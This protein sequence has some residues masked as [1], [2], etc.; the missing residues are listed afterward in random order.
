MRLIL[1]FLVV[2][3]LSA[4]DLQNQKNIA[5]GTLERDRIAHAATSNEV[6]I[7]LPVPKGS[8]V[9]KGDIL[10]Q[11]DPTQ[12][13]A[14]VARAIAKVAEAKA[15]FEKLQH[16][17]RKEEIA[18]ARANVA[19][20]QAT[21]VESEANYKRTQNLAKSDLSSQALLDRTLADRDFHLASLLSV[22]EQLDALIKGTRQEDLD[23]AKA[24]LDA[25]E[26]MLAGEKKKLADL[27]IVA[28]RDGILDNLPWNLGERVTL[29]SPVAVILAGKAP[30]ARIYV[31]ETHRINIKVND[32]LIIHIDGME[33]PVS[34]SL[35]WI[36]N[37]PAFS[38]YYA[39]NQEE[40]SR[41]MYLA[42]V[43]LS[44]EDSA[45]PNGIPVQVEL[46]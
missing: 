20:A 41:L 24:R 2:L 6:I 5:L 12:Q 27:T 30:F 25:T 7:E 38:P 43:Q 3:Q 8:Q 39:L 44:A 4:C 22:K 45:L 31:P 21:L 16:G 34:G 26:A 42:E 36:S 1:V 18:A 15:N 13:N 23:I 32:S 40:R 10:V 46:P 19:G 29:G 28:T 35:R 14:Y 33:K 9:S 11:L 37:E 17:A